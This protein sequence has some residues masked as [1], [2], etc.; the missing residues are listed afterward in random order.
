MTIGD[1]GGQRT[2][3][4]ILVVEDDAQVMDLVSWALEEEGFGI[5]AASD[6]YTALAKAR[7]QEPSLVLLD[8]TLPDIDG[9]VVADSLRE[10]HGGVV[11]IVLM[12]ADG[13]SAEKAKRV[14]AVAFFH[15][16]FDVDTL[17][18]SVRRALE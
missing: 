9:D 3:K 17:L 5:V 16:P 14:G 4:P 1:T 2:T 11:P 18:A 6:G 8:W 7:E 15:K 13:R 10:L 12:T